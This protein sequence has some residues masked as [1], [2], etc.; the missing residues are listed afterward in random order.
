MARYH[1]PIKSKE[2]NLML[3][4]EHDEKL[5]KY[6]LS[7]SSSIV[8]GAVDHIHVLFSWKTCEKVEFWSS[9]EQVRFETSKI[10]GITA[11]RNAL[12]D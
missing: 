11:K 2:D 9:E 8:K 6:E 5:R 12:K 7:F 4:E 10:K 3:K 1:R